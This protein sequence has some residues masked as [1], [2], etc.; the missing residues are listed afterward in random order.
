[1][2]CVMF[3]LTRPQKQSCMRVKIS[4]IGACAVTSVV[5]IV[6]SFAAGAK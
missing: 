5:V 1:M 3:F 6:I 4:E 2:P